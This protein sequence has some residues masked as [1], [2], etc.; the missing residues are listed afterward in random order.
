MTVTAFCAA[1]SATDCSAHS[2]RSEYAVSVL[3]LPV[4]R[5]QLRAE[6][7]DGRYSIRFSGKVKGLARLFSDAEASARASGTESPARLQPSSYTHSVTEDDKTETV[8]LS[9]SGSDVSAVSA[10]PPRRHP[11]RYVPVTTAD[12]ANVIDPVTALV[13]PVTEPAAAQLCDRTLP[14]F[15]GRQRFD[16]VLSYSRTEVVE[17]G[18]DGYSGPAA[19]CAIRYR[20]ISGHRPGKE[21]VEFMAANKDLEVWMAPV[22]DLGVAAPVKIRIRTSFGPLVLEAMRFEADR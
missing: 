21:S 8:R 14:L 19:V 11:E 18:D 13:W 20:P 4:G 2:L 10:E 16:L 22:G 17:G 3:G 5:A 12:K 15:D 9:F 6:F 1:G 7:G